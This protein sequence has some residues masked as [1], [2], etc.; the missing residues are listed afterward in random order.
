M[1]SKKIEINSLVVFNHTEG[2]TMF[3][4][5][6]ISGFN[7][8]VIDATIEDEFPNQKIQYIDMSCAKTPNRRQLEIWNSK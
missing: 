4:V 6:E 1:A 5:K 8:G 2:A 3:R 7:I